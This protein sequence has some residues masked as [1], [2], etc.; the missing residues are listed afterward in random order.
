[1]SRAG[2]PWWLPLAAGSAATVLR[3]VGRT[4]RIDERNAPEYDAAVA[5]GERF[6]Y[7]FWHARLLPLA[8]THRGEGIAVLVSRHRDGELVTR[9]IEAL[10]FVTARGSST[11][12]GE[13]GLREMVAWA[14]R[15]A[16]LAVTPDGPRGP[17]E[18]AKDGV[19]YLATRLGRRVVPIGTSADRAWVARSWDR[20]RAPKPFARVSIT[21]GAPITLARDL[22]GE[23]FEAARV[24]VEQALRDVT[25]DV[26]RRAGE[27]A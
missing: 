9:V 14:G 6:V 3:G 8:F 2:Y 15:D 17:A 18:Q 20:F 10:G 23:A 13:A 1:M 22:Q 11:R 5:T 12:G 25:A 21:H 26:R 4:W 7:C 24:Q 19:V 27:G 16:Q